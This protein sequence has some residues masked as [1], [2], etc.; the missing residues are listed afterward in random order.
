M[1]AR[2]HGFLFADGVSE[3]DVQDMS[4]IFKICKIFRIKKKAVF[5]D[6]TPNL[7]NRVN[8]VNPA[9]C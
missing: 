6:V 7:A 5:D 1:H 2:F 9:S 3:Q 8:R 4:R